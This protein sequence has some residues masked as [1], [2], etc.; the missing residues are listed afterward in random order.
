MCGIAGF[1]G[2]PVA[3]SSD[4]LRRMADSLAHRGPD[5][6]G[7]WEGQAGGHVRVGLAH[8]RLAIVDL[9]TGQQPLTNER[10]TIHVICNGEIYNYLELRQ[11]LQRAGH[12]FRTDSDTET[13]VHGYEEYGDAVLSE[14]RGMFAIALWD[15]EQSRL[16]LARDR[17]GEKPLF[18]AE[19]GDALIFASEIKS[20]LKWPG[21][22]ARLDVEAVPQFLQYRYLPGPATLL[23]GIRK[24]PPGCLAIWQKGV[25]AQRRYYTPPDGQPRA[26][27]PRSADPARAIAEQ[28]DESVRL[29]MVSDVAFGAFLSGGL[30]SS[31]I[32]ALMSRHSAQPVRTYSVG[33]EEAGYSELAYAAQVA[34]S[35]GTAHH[36]LLLTQQHVIDLLPRAAALRD[37]PLAEPADLALF[38]LASE[39]RRTVKMVLTGE[40]S[41]EVLAGYPK[42]A[43]EAAAQATM[44]RLPQALLQYFVKPVAEALPYG[45]RR[46][47]IALRA[48]AETNFERRMPLWFGALTDVEVRRLFGRWPQAAGDDTAFPFG[49]A[50]GSA[51]RRIL[52]FDQTSWLPDNLLERGD[53]M[54]MAAS[55]E[56]R[57][58]FLDHR[59]VELAASL[60]DSQRVRGLTG[61][62]VL[63]MAM[64][65]IL[66]STIV[67]RSKVGFRVPV[68]R[69]LSERL[70][71]LLIEA[72]SGSQSVV[73]ALLDR[74]VMD[75]IV[76]Q[77]L[78]GRR[79]HEKLL[80]M[81]L[82]L[83][84]WC[85][86]NSVS[87]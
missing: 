69:W 49:A 47:R 11:R 85:Q 9:V 26:H 52:Y 3:D 10:G 81:L 83:H 62:Y 57:M 64:K 67:Q 61:K 78:T 40:G 74:S 75:E 87:I 20:I 82:S 42:H 18:L 28:L 38:L 24:L 77:H 37:A 80:W 72:V 84:L 32:V 5:G 73:G 68:H 23:K 8:R 29:M 44:R 2:H 86:V 54:T 15:A 65:E 31:A 45:A 22:S 25:L 30:D 35:F 58:P 16:L 60:P 13:I 46:A 70:R 76:R 34:R 79:N 21:L 33:F 6:E 71:P 17:F 12:R 53:R 66:P 7:F 14:L 27:E 50:P 51:L 48:L 36:E 1:V 56:A 43:F 55:L 63:R 19:T 39:A 4:V 59:L 41:D